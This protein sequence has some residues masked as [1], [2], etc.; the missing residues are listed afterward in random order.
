MAGGQPGWLAALGRDAAALVAH[1]GLAVSIVLA[2][3]LAAVAIGVYL[4]AP[5]ARAV[6]VLA[7][8]VAALIW[9]IGEAFGGILAGGATDPNSGLPLI[10]LAVAYWPARPVTAPPPGPADVPAGLAGKGAPA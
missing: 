4:P 3:V 6:L 9:V 8:V 7:V 10:L 1:Q 5:A 2:A